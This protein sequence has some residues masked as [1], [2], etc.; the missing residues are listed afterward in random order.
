MSHGAPH[1][2][3][4]TEL[5]GDGF[6]DPYMSIYTEERLDYGLGF[7]YDFLGLSSR[8]FTVP[9]ASPFF[10]GDTFTTGNRNLQMATVGINYR[11]NWASPVV[12][13]Y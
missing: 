1:Y 2:L 3:M 13:K 11:F 5:L 6:R 12:A 7:E 4:A 9:V 8:T 10:A